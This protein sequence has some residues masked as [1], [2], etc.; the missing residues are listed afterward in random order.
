MVCFDSLILYF[1]FVGIRRI[2]PLRQHVHRMLAE[3]LGGS[4]YARVSVL[5]PYYYE[6]GEK[7]HLQ[8]L[9][10]RLL[11]ALLSPRLGSP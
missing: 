8:G 7:F 2:N 5:T 6:I 10:W 9:F 3:I 1:V 11:I 4:H